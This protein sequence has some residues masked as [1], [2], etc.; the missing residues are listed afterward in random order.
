MLQ[1]YFEKYLIF[2]FFLPVVGHFTINYFDRRPIY[3]YQFAIGVFFILILFNNKI[4]KYP[5]FIN[6]LL[7]YTIYIW[8][9]NIFN[10]YLF[11]KGV[12]KYLFTNMYMYKVFLLIIIYRFFYTQKFIENIV[13]LIKVWFIV[14]IIGQL[15]Q[16]FVDPTLFIP[17]DGYNE[18]QNQYLDRRYSVFVL[19]SD[20][21]GGISIL[22]LFAIYFG[23]YIKEKNKTPWVGITTAIIY[24]I[25]SN[26]RFI[27]LGVL[28]ILIPTLFTKEQFIKNSL[29]IFPLILILFIGSIILTKYLHFDFQEY[30]EQRLFREGSIK[31]TSRYFAFTTFGKFF[32]EHPVFGYGVHLTDEMKDFIEGK[33]SQIHVGYLQH[34]VSYGIA[35]SIILFGFWFYCLQFL[36]R[37]AKKTKFYGSFYGFLMIIW[38]N[39]TLVTYEI[40]FVGIILSFVFDKYYW[41]RYRIQQL[42]RYN[43]LAGEKD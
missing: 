41:D 1:K 27:M 6:W 12:A 28:I 3:F 17:F 4:K 42:Q 2:L 5:K 20:G 39:V 14:L 40:F 43:A 11:T 23:Y 16:F 26:T 22:A 9:W 32:P 24:A 25:L 37:R 36:Y 29:K 18:D 21:E 8:V 7:F 34:L 33:S 35:G 38:G 19:V 30:Y 13:L 15:L 31:N 10:D